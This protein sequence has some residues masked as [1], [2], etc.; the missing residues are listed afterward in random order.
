MAYHQLRH[1]ERLA[2]VDYHARKSKEAGG[3]G[4]TLTEYE[5]IMNG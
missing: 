5:L 4:L 1:E 2:R 3:E